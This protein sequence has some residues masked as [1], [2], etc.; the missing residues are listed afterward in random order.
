MKTALV[1]LNVSYI[2]KNLALR[3]LYVARPADAEVRVIEGSVRAPEACLKELIAYQP[4]VVGLSVYI[5]N[6]EATRILIRGLRDALPK[7]RI[8]CGGPEATYNPEALWASPI[9]GIIRGEGEFA[10]WEALN[11]PATPG[12]QTRGDQDVPVLKTELSRL[13]TLESPYFLDFDAPDMDKR[14]L[15][16]ETSRG[17]PYGCSYCMAS[18]DRKVRL[19][20][21]PYLETFF[22]RLKTSPVRQVKF[23]DRTFNLEPKRAMHLAQLC[24]SVPEPMTFHVELVGDSLSKDLRELFLTRA[25]DR[26][27]LE[28]GI[29]SFR[30]ETLQAVGRF[31]DLVKLETVV[32]DFALAGLHQ[33][34]DLIAGLPYQTL[35]SFKEDLDR[36]ARLCPQEIQVGILKLLKGSRLEAEKERWGYQSETQAPYQILCSE[37]MD[38][39]D[40]RRIEAVALAMEKTYNSGRFKTELEPLFRDLTLSPFRLLEAIGKSLKGLSHPYTDQAFYLAV[41]EGLKTEMPEERARILCETAYYRHAKTKPPRLFPKEPI[42]NLQ[43]Y[44][45]HLKAL[46]PDLERL[47]GIYLKR[48]APVGLEAWYYRHQEHLV[49][50]L[51]Q[52]GNPIRH[53]TYPS[54][55]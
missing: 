6:L 53:A 1:S 15:Y 42:E 29:Q 37:W 11:N 34:T 55:P 20:S 5:F 41:Y 40:V 22:D 44:L 21:L 35:A 31:S 49:Y 30:T 4:E 10:F 45:N 28:I 38:A 26:F 48:T 50:T 51:D 43:L 39:S 46:D 24:L 12:F 14:Y 16:A 23:L 52:E 33:H 25:K 8:L 17:C 9:N 18:L 32:S 13:E 2:H 7:V 19:F 54:H 3:W 47:N 27:R 36:L